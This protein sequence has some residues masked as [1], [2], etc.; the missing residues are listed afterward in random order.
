MKVKI[1]KNFAESLFLVFTLQSNHKCVIMEHEKAL[2]FLYHV[3]A[4]MNDEISRINSHAKQTYTRIFDRTTIK[5]AYKAQRKRFG[6]RAKHMRVRKGP[7]GLTVCRNQHC[8]LASH[9]MK[10]PGRRDICRYEKVGFCP[11]CHAPSGRKG[12]C[13]I[14]QYSKYTVG[15]HRRHRKIGRWKFVCIGGEP[16]IDFGGEVVKREKKLVKWLEEK[17][18]VNMKRERER[19]EEH[20]MTPISLQMDLDMDFQSDQKGVESD[21]IMNPVSLKLIVQ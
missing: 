7:N 3:I 6:R 5:N 17:R 8:E 1:C 14:H 21:H 15:T 18:K 2:N 13:Y 10:R 11:W 19:N 4:K 12:A 9:L 20:I 16:F